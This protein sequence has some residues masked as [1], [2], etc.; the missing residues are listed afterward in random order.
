MYMKSPPQNDVI[1]FL[2]IITALLNFQKA[3][4][5]KFSQYDLKLK[6]NF[7][8]NFYPIQDSPPPFSLKIGRVEYQLFRF[9][10]VMFQY[11]HHVEHTN[12][13]KGKSE[14]CFFNLLLTYCTPMGK[15]AF[16]CLLAYKT[17]I[18][19]CLILDYQQVNYIHCR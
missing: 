15:S 13:S 5:I 1:F 11:A 10:S 9:F 14:T 16:S 4:F 6:Q 12:P 17:V 2:C 3:I 7:K 19:K 18:I 8:M